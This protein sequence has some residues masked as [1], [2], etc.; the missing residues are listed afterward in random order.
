ML[1]RVEELRV[2]HPALAG[3]E[4][5]LQQQKIVLFD[6][7]D[8]DG[9]LTGS[10]PTVGSRR[11]SHRDVVISSIITED[12]DVRNA[13]CNLGHPSTATLLRI[14][15]RSSASDAAQRYARWWKCLLRA[16]RQAPRALN[17]TTAPYRPNTFN[18][19]IGCDVKAIYDANGLNFEALNIVDLAT[20]FQ[21]LAILD[22]PSSTECTEKLWLWWMLWAG[23]PKTIV[24]D[25]GTSFRTAFQMM[26]ERYGASS[27]AAPIESPWHIGMVERC[28]KA[29][30]Q[31]PERPTSQQEPVGK[32]ELR[33][34]PQLGVRAQ[35]HGRFASRQARRVASR[36]A[37]RVSHVD[38][39]RD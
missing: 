4:A 29:G 6:V 30:K 15:R 1:L 12:V 37:G 25:L 26:V 23:P 38:S 3:L 28:R 34:D 10:S 2:E 18:S 5:W 14:M 36:Q 13:H 17:P 33:S 8:D 24:S 32:L 7:G 35:L 27:R 16:Q 20:G 39:P 19:M 11:S 21:I 22:G 31:P 9:F